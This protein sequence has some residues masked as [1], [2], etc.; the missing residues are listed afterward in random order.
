MSDIQNPNMR[1][2]Q[3][4]VDLYRHYAPKI[5]LKQFDDTVLSITVYNEGVPFSAHTTV[6]LAELPDKSVITQKYDIKTNDGLIEITLDKRIVNNSGE[7]KFELIFL[8]EENRQISTFVFSGYVEEGIFTGEFPVDG[9][10]FYT[11]EGETFTTSDGKT[12]YVTKEGSATEYISVH[13]GQEI[14]KAVTDVIEKVWKNDIPEAIDGKDGATIIMGDTDPEPEEGNINDIFYNTE[15]CDIF[16]KTAAFMPLATEWTY[17]GNNRGK[18]GR[19]GLDGKDG[20]NGKDGIDGEDGKD[21][22]LPEPWENIAT[23]KYVEDQ[24]ENAIGSILAGE[25]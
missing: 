8:D 17:K 19:D 3:L 12:F 10:E 25:F 6:L 18:D 24:I 2:I 5:A 14:D 20:E 7:V 9:Q 22:E 11:S 15:T 23:K 16:Q 4:T 13:K 1:Y 21:A